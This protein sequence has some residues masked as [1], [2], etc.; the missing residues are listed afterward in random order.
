MAGS[1]PG[2][3]GIWNSHFRVGGAAG[4]FVR[5]EN[6]TTPATSLAAW[7]HLH[8]T[9]TSS[10]YVENMWG[11]TADHDLDGGWGN[12]N[13]S[14]GRGALI[15]ATRGTWLVGSAMEH[16]TLYQYNFNNATNIASVFQQSETPYWQGPGNI[17]APG[18]WTGALQPSDPTYPN[19]IGSGDGQCGMALF[20]IINQSS[21]LFLYGGC[22]WVFKNNQDETCFSTQGSLCQQNGIEISKS[23]NTNLYGTNMLKVDQVLLCDT[24]GPA[25]QADNS[26]GWGSVVAGY[27]VP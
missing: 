26:G 21:N 15:E 9:N 7:G 11:W 8:L 13:I 2:D 1:Q 22:L 27:F 3:V 5:N 18:P 23:R 6:C 25:T 20:E 14:V 24:V 4:T 12:L 10:A 16:N 19:C 17:L